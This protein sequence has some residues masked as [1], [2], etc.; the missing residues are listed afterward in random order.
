MYQLPKLIKIPFGIIYFPSGVWRHDCWFV[1]GKVFQ[2]ASDLTD[3]F[4]ETYVTSFLVHFLVLRTQLVVVWKCYRLFWSKSSNL[5]EGIFS[6]NFLVQ[7]FLLCPGA[8]ET[9]PVYAWVPYW[10]YCLQNC[11][12]RATADLCSI[13]HPCLHSVSS[14]LTSIFEIEKPELHWV[15]KMLLYHGLYINKILSSFLFAP[16]LVCST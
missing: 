13:C 10:H 8:E 16:F 3:S 6:W 12:F 4:I 1:P 2:D 15:F 11:S 5:S 9:Q 7:D 14:G